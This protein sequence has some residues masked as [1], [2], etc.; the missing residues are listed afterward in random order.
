MRIAVKFAKIRFF[1]ERIQ[2]KQI[3][4]TSKI[5]LFFYAIG[6]TTPKQKK[7]PINGQ[8]FCEFS[9]FYY[10]ENLISRK[11]TVLSPLGS[12]VVSDL[13]M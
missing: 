5:Q 10:F 2:C 8:L 12:V 3:E 4:F 7:L 11:V 13:V 6:T 9:L 1:K